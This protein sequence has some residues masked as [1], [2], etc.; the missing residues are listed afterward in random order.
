MAM[1]EILYEGNLRTR[2]IHQETKDEILTDAPKDNQGKG[3]RISPTDLVAAALGSCIA[4]LI[5]I[6]ANKQQVDVAGL[7]VV[8]VKEM[9]NFPLRRIGK[10]LI[11][12]YC[13][14]TFSQEV[15]QILEKMAIYCPVHE[16]LHPDIQ[17]TLR[18]H[19]GTR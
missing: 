11:D 13:P 5:G 19:W 17:Q 18:F 8:V 16:S 1:I 6:G 2:C 7:R 4:T 14:Q 15:T 12:V 10:L 3:E 9:A